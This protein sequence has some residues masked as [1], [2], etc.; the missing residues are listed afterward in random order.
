MIRKLLIYDWREEVNNFIKR[1][2][3]HKNNKIINNWNK[4]HRLEIK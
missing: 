3:E 2:R 1:F 4:S